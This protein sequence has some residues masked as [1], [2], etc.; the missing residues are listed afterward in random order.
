[1][2]TAA[3]WSYLNNPF[4]NVTKRSYKRMMALA[5]DHRDKLKNN[6]SDPD[7]DM[8]YKQFEVKYAA[9]RRAY[10]LSHRSAGAYMAATQK[11][12]ALFAEL[13]GMQ[14]RK[15]DIAIQGQYIEGT[16]E[17]TD[18][19]PEFRQPFQRGAY[20]SRLAA[21][22]VLAEALGSYP[23]LAPVQQDVQKFS[24]TLEE[25]RT[26]QQGR[27]NDEQTLSRNLEDAREQ[28][29]AVM[30]GIL[31]YLIYKYQG[32]VGRVE[33]FYEMLYIRSPKTDTA[34]SLKT[35]KIAASGRI[36]AFDGQLENS[37]YVTLRNT[38]VM[39]IVYFT[40]SNPANDAPADVSTLSPGATAEF[41]P[42][43]ESDGTG[44]NWLVVLNKSIA[45]TTI[46][47]GKVD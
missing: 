10:D 31:G 43:E 37:A 40:T 2:Q 12:E 45:E 8:L 42:S 46:E 47:L 28:L 4:D 36:S 19:M 29:A 14:I 44:F 5:T 7:I 26:I 13:S 35:Y 32:D 21:L 9:F 39:P 34:V 23:A 20:D 3:S 11:V 1:M 41:Y 15:W 22:R 17:Y 18:L 25:A 24:D 30:Q 38:G 33:G 27:E 6:C 16:P